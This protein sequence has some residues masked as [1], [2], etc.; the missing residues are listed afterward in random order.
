MLAREPPRHCQA[1]KNH[2][3]PVGNQ[4]QRG[5]YKELGGPEWEPN[6]DLKTH[7]NYMDTTDLE[8]GAM[9]ETKLFQSFTVLLI[10]KW[11]S[12]PRRRDGCSKGGGE[13]EEI[14]GLNEASVG[15]NKSPRIRKVYRVRG[16]E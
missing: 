4:T 16:N 8:G 6:I 9:R 3:Q 11:T 12:V 7:K 1:R 14:R 13:E 15:Q 2:M 5:G 10:L